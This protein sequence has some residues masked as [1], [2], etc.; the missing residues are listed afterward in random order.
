MWTCP[1]LLA[2]CSGHYGNIYN[3][4]VSCFK[5]VTNFNATLCNYKKYAS[6]H[7]LIWRCCLSLLCFTLTAQPGSRAE[8]LLSESCLLT[9]QSRPVFLFDW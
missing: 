6:Q 1:F 9:S 3:G 2:L 8:M 4:T 5:Y 7:I